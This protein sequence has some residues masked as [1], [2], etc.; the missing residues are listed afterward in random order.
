MTSGSLP[1]RLEPCGPE[2][3]LRPE[4][5][6]VEL[7]IGPLSALRSFH[8]LGFIVIARVQRAVECWR[9]AGRN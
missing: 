2:V 1:G 5:H 7:R 9:G 3:G 4:A 8:F 6:G